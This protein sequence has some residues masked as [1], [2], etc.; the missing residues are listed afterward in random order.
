MIIIHRFLLSQIYSIFDPL[1][2]LYF[3]MI[4]YKLVLQEIVLQKYE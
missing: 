1:V 2:L 3:I 4:H